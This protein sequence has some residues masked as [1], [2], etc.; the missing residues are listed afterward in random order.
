MYM[1]K[2]KKKD[3]IAILAKRL[4]LVGDAHRI[5]IICCIMKHKKVCVSDIV[6]DL[7]SNIAI[8][9]HHLQV[10]AKEGILVSD[11]E[12]KKISYKLNKNNFTTDLKRLICK[13]K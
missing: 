11:R 4:Y 6:K 13:Y 1:I 9:S 2:N 8:V 12:G 10:L 7:G 5:K 3:Y